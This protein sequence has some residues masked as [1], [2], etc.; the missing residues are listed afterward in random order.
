MNKVLLIPV[1]VAMTGC[2]AGP[3]D[4]VSE[5]QA[6]MKSRPGVVLENSAR[7][8]DAV[9]KFAALY[10]DLSPSNVETQVRGAY[11][12]DAWF[13]DTIATKVGVQAIEAY[14]LRTAQDTSEVKA[15]IDDVAVSGADCYVRWSMTVRTPNLAGGRPVI[16]SGMSQ[17]RFDEEGRIV[18][19]QDYWNPASGIYQHLPVVGPVLHYIDGLIA[20]SK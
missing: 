8:Q 14:L 13:N 2:A 10:A 4:F 17:L 19:H 12:P 11:A 6:A 15:V 16:T 7:A 18:L 1:L 3:T 9:K 5:Y 20:G